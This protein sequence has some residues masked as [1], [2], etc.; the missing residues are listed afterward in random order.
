MLDVNSETGGG[1]VGS[2]TSILAAAVRV[3]SSPHQSLFGA[4]C[5][6]DPYR[7]HSTD[8]TPFETFAVCVHIRTM[9][10][11]HHHHSATSVHPPK[12]L[13]HTKTELQC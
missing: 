1:L 12:A 3:S 13:P 6:D 9:K 2:K 5:E 8:T 7:T 11:H 10:G 4:G